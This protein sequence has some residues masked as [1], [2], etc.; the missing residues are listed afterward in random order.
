MAHLS[1]ISPPVCFLFCT[2]AYYL[3]HAHARCTPAFFFQDSVF[4]RRWVENKNWR[5]SVPRLRGSE[6]GLGSESWLCSQEVLFLTA[7]Y[8]H[9]KRDPKKMS[10]TH[11]FHCKHTDIYILYCSLSPLLSYG[12]FSFSGRG[13]FHKEVHCI[14]ET[15]DRLPQCL[16]T[17]TENQKRKHSIQ[18]QLRDTH[19]YFHG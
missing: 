11:Y 1:E 10:Q 8:K 17:T 18:F 6:K 13:G 16:K 3:K 4:T 19:F 15:A 14:P 12:T 9:W 7:L 5:Q 2:C